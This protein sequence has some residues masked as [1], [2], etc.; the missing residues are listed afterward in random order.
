[1][2]KGYRDIEAAFARAHAVVEMEVSV[3]RHSGVPMETRGAL[4]WFDAA[5]GVLIM[6][7]AAK[8][9]HF[10]RDAIARMLELPPGMVQLAEGHV[11]GGFGVRGELYPEDVLVCQAAMRFGRAVKWVEDRHEHLMA[12]NHSRD[13]THRLRAAVDARG[14]I[15]GLEDEF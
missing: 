4:A 1:M 10:N 5:R 9:P 6:Q 7:G 2:R 14:F 13:Q 8:V 12:A 3:G 11:G 15:L